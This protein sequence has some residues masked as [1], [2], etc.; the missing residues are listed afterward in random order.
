ML[1]ASLRTVA[2]IAS[3]N[4]TC[5]CAVRLMPPMNLLLPVNSA[6]DWPSTAGLDA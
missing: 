2:A 6:F 3:F 5:N 4:Q 1:Q